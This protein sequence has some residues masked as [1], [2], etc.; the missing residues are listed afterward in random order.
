MMRNHGHNGATPS[1]GLDL[2]RR[3]LDEAA[4]ALATAVPPPGELHAIV[5]GAMQVSTAL[6]EVVDTLIRQ[7][8]AA[9]DGHGHGDGHLL[10]ELEYD[11]RGMHG[12]LVTAPLLLAPARDDLDTLATGGNAEHSEEDTMLDDTPTADLADQQRPARP[13]PAD[14]ADQHRHVPVIADDEPWP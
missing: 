5:D 12:C 11:L 6:A 10:R 9:L 8:P 14:V 13:D 3:H 1:W 4:R 7:A 2:A